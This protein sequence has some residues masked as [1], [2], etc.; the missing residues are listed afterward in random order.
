MSIY[1]TAIPPTAGN[2]IPGGVA[3]NSGSDPTIIYGG[4]KAQYS[5]QIVAGVEHELSMGVVLSA[6]FVHTDLKRIVED[7]SGI[8]VEQYNA[9][10]GQQYVIQNPNSHSDTFH[11]AVTCTSGP[12][13]DP[14]VGFTLDSGALGRTVQPDGF[15]DASPCLQR[16]ATHRRKAVRQEL[17]VAGELQP[18]EALRKLRRQFPE[19]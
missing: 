14:S 2:V 12:N 18:G 19:R 9:G 5:E 11:N 13:C 7:T 6:R 4:T 15:P 16:H 3:S 1:S 10:S 17:V 8:T